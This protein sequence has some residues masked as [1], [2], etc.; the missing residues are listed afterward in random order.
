MLFR[1]YIS[2]ESVWAQVYFW[3]KHPVTNHSRGRQSNSASF[4]THVGNLDWFPN[5]RFWFSLA[6]GKW[7][8]RSFP[9]SL[10]FKHCI[11]KKSNF[12]LVFHFFNL[13]GHF[14][15]SVIFY[16]FHW[17]CLGVVLLLCIMCST[18]SARFFLICASC[19]FWKSIGNYIFKYSFP[20]PPCLHDLL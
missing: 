3:L 12:H 9:V 10:T 13:S 8:G 5:S 7:T 17:T 6:L 1:A 16:V 20:P 15:S 14:S 4:C 18:W 19:Q 2:S 11:K